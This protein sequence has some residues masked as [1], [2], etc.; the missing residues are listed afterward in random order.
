MKF[1]IVFAVIGLFVI[2]SEAAYKP[3]ET[4]NYAAD[5][6]ENLGTGGLHIAADLYS[7][8]KTHL[9][10]DIRKTLAYTIEA[11]FDDFIKNLFKI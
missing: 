6:V 11:A 7:K 3:A 9:S 10:E 8:N 2:V 1:L 4:G 5:A